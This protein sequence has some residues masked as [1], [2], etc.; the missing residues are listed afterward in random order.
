MCFAQAQDA[1]D[2][3]GQWLQYGALGLVIV[4]FLL[5]WLWAKPAVDRIIREN[6]S[7]RQRLDRCQDER[8]NELREL[9]NEV[10][11]LADRLGR[12]P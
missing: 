2:L 11:N 3:I 1:P 6:E 8:T 9:R 12:D 7:L 5:G 4:G 10:R